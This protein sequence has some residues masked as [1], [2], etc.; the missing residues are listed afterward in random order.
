M[1]DLIQFADFATLAEMIQN[2]NG[3]VS[4][5]SAAEAAAALDQRMEAI[6]KRLS[7]IREQEE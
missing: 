1:A 6:Q 2:A 4:G 5:M 7:Q 3:A